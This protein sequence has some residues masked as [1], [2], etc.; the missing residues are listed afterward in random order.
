MKLNT[1]DHQSPLAPN[2]A[3]QTQSPTNKHKQS[4]IYQ[5][6]KLLFAKKGKMG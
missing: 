2:Q 6:R 3:M 1:R 4:E 5:T